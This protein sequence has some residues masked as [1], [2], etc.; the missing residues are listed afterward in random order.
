MQKLTVD[1]NPYTRDFAATVRH[2]LVAGYTLIIPQ[3]KLTLHCC[4]RF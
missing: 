4:F 3:Y 2:F 1:L